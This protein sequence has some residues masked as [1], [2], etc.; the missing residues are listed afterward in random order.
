MS[1]KNPVKEN[2]FVISDNIAWEATDEGVQR[3]V[4]GYDEQLMLVCVQFEKGAAGS[5][6]HHIHRQVSYVESGSFEVTIGGNKKILQKGD[7]FFVKPN[8]IHGVVA[9]EKG[10]LIDVFTP[11]R[12]D[13]I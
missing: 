13:F 2:P 8:L 11:A 12:E 4:L 1:A 9:L 7:C 10:T 6:H 5:P 3:K